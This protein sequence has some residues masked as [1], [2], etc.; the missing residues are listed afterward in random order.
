MVILSSLDEAIACV[1][2]LFY[3]D[4]PYELV[5]S[6]NAYGSA[7]FRLSTNTFPAVF[8]GCGWKLCQTTAGV[9]Y[10]IGHTTAYSLP[11]VFPL[12]YFRLNP[13]LS[14][15]QLG[16]VDNPFLPCQKTIEV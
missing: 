16:I 12:M 5:D 10:K 9:F 7:N 1:L 3:C 11:T 13:I 8:H 14:L 6:D 2:D 15:T 4:A